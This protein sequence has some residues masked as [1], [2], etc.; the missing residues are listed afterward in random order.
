MKTLVIYAYFETPQSVGNLEFFSEVGM[1]PD[2]RATFVVVVNGHRC[3]IPLAERPDRLVLRRENTGFDFGAHRHGLVHLSER[4][5]CRVDELP[6]DHFL[7]INSSAAGPFLPAYFPA[8]RH[9]TSVFT[10]RLTTRVKLVGPSITCL[11]RTDAGGYGP[12]VEGYCFATDR[13]GLGIL[14]QDG[15][16]FVD[17]PTKFSAIVDGEYGASRAILRAGFGLDCLLYKYQGLDW[18]DPA[19][20]DQNGNAPPSRQGTYEGISIHPFEVVF[21]KWYWS[22]HPDR[23]VAYDYFERY[24]RWK[25]DQVR[26]AGGEPA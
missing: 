23:P 17:H 20:W 8:E 7:F 3:S 16:V 26:R 18:T 4:Y 13:A 15:R 19:N 25:L 21:H 2:E 10:S 22:H 1:A 6:F 11:A 12:R 5:G 9:W 14:W 24:R